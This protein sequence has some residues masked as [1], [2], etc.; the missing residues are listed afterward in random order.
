MSIFQQ[1]YETYV[2]QDNAI[3]IQKN[4][5]SVGAELKVMILNLADKEV[6]RKL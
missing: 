2:K 4:K 6:K 5:Y 1:K 3:H